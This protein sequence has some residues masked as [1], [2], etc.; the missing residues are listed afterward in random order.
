MK[1]F[2]HLAVVSMFIY[3][4]PFAQANSVPSSLLVDQPGVV[5]VNGKYPNAIV[6]L[7]ITDS[8]GGSGLD[9]GFMQGETF[10]WVHSGWQQKENLIF[11]S[12]TAVD[13]AVRSKGADKQSGTDDDQVFRLSDSAHYAN[14]YYSDAISPWES[15]SSGQ[16]GNYYQS[17]TLLWDIDRNGIRD[18]K[19]T[20]RARAH[21]GMYYAA[22]TP[23][24]LPAAI[25]LLIT[26]LAGL[27]MVA[28]RRVGIR[29]QANQP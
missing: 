24:P 2:F 6:A 21:D 29:D 19:I 18:L 27:T 25:W 10:S 4:G 14:Q 20:L 13:F 1:Q 17:L 16:A 12:G 9:F 26:G 7:E 22:A 28:R 3:H 11:A 8:R 15:P 23:V 5:M